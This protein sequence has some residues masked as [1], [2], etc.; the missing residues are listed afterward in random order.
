MK[1]I[2]SYIEFDEKEISKKDV[3]KSIFGA[4]LLVYSKIWLDM[5]RYVYALTDLLFK[6]YF[7][8]RKMRKSYSI[9]I[10]PIAYGDMRNHVTSRW[11]VFNGQD[12]FGFRV[13]LKKLQK[14]YFILEI[15][16]KEKKYDIVKYFKIDGNKLKQ[17]NRND[18]IDSLLA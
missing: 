14:E 10:I 11:K 1:D 6:R 9:K 12:D 7:W 5:K 18:K 3:Y 8:Y 13:Y 4:V 16:K 2:D 17:Y 15:W